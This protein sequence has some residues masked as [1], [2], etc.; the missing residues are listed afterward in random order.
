MTIKKMVGYDIKD[1]LA[2]AGFA[3]RRS[4]RD[5]LLPAAGLVALGA[6]AGAG[7]ALMFAPSS[8]SR[9]RKDF[10]DRIGRIR[11]RMTEAQRT[12]EEAQKA[13]VLN[14]TQR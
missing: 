1:V 12:K 4:L 2:L 3:R 13:P 7:L 14:A 11:E 9:L 10:G 6:A 5:L 8:G